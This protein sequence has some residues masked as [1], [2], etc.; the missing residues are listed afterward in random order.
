MDR[1]VPIIDNLGVTPKSE[2]KFHLFGLLPREIRRE[3]YILATPPR[4]VCVEEVGRE[5]A[6]WYDKLEEFTETCR[7]T[8]IQFKLHPDLLY[9]A[10]NWAPAIASRLRSHNQPLLEAYGFTSTKDRY[11]PW[12]PTEDTPE[13]PSTWL[14]D[15]PKVAWI[16]ARSA[17]L[18]SS[19]PIPPF[20]HVW[21]ESREMLKSYG[22]QLVFGTRTD[23]PRTWFH[24]ERDT[25]L[26]SYVSPEIENVLVGEGWDVSLFRPMD[27]QR[28]K[29][30]A[31]RSGFSAMQDSYGGTSDL[32][33]IL[34]LLPNLNDLFFVQRSDGTACG[35][36]ASTVVNTRDYHVCV[37]VDEADF[38]PQLS[39][40]YDY[41][42]SP[43]SDLKAFKSR[44][45]EGSA[46]S[47]CRYFDYAAIHTRR[48]ICSER[49]KLMS[50]THN[51]TTQR[52]NVP[53]MQLTHVCSLEGAEAIFSK[54]RQFW[55][56]FVATKNR[57][58]RG[59]ISRLNT[60]KGESQNIPGYMD[61]GEAFLR[62]HEPD[63]DEQRQFYIAHY[64]LPCYC[65]QRKFTL[66][67]SR[68]GLWWLTEAVVLPPRFDI[69]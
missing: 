50:S 49:S 14:A 59:R 34:R 54:R 35:C 21:S 13:I 32:L 61:V 8:P 19:A 9:F 64:N 47:H 65:M 17:S 5:S 23:E 48:R 20:L 4:V 63:E 22:Y 12:V 30:L 2:A 53:R 18:Y 15:H 60:L 31:L 39:E 33:T 25:L 66:P 29:R 57:L 10:H 41:V 38:I 26:I 27:L 3:I 46:L 7:T 62:A 68:E 6:A 28:V 52:W 37:S 51:N 40:F 44:N 69:L 36:R 43:Y 58:A 55:N 24:F 45:R 67:V 16:M 56:Q 1:V 11:L 42:D